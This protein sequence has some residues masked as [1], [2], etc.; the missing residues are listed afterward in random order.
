MPVLKR[1]QLAARPLTDLHAIASQLG[2]ARFRLLRKPELAAAILAA[3][4]EPANPD[5]ESG[6]SAR[7]RRRRRRRPRE[8]TGRTFARVWAARARAAHISRGGVQNGMSSDSAATCSSSV[9]RGRSRNWIPYG[10]ATMSTRWRDWPSCCQVCWR[11][12]PVTATLR[13]VSR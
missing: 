7:K 12:R 2:I 11:S 9:S 8:S 5:P 4:A 1:E 13:P 6:R 3:Q 10:S